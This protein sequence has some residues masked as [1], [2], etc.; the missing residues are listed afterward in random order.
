MLRNHLLS[1]IKATVGGEVVLECIMFRP[2]YIHKQGIQN[3]RNTTLQAFQEY[4]VT[5]IYIQHI[6]EKEFVCT[7][8][9]DSLR[10]IL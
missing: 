2:P 5:N 8:A 9:N 7:T 4:N 10:Y 6:C 1:I 3:I